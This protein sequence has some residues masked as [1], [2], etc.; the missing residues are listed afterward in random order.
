[1]TDESSIVPQH[2][3]GWT[4]AAVAEPGLGSPGS[5][6]DTGHSTGQMQALVTVVV[7]AVFELG[8]VLLGTRVAR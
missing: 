1:M 6:V 4:Q 3:C 2:S 8:V 7:A 5:V